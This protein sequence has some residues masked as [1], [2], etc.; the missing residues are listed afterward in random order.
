VKRLVVALGVLAI[1]GTAQAQ[2]LEPR[3][4][5]SEPSSAIP[6]SDIGEAPEADRYDPKRVVCRRT[7]PPTGTRVVRGKRSEKICLAQDEW[8]RRSEL[9]QETLKQRDRGTCGSE[10]CKLPVGGPG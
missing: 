7:K 1:A 2:M 6:D 4:P 5:A 3:A 8:D 10:G 9:G